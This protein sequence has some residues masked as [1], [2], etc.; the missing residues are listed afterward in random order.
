MSRR[1]CCSTGQFLCL[2]AANPHLIW[3][4]TAVEFFVVHGFTQA[5]P[6]AVTEPQFTHDFTNTGCLTVHIFFETPSIS[7]LGWW[8]LISFYVMNEWRTRFLLWALRYSPPKHFW[9][10]SSLVA[11][12]KERRRFS[13]LFQNE[14]ISSVSFCHH[15]VPENRGS[16]VTEIGNP[17]AVECPLIPKSYTRRPPLIPLLLKTNRQ[18]I[19]Y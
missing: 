8:I 10:Q 5:L 2:A 13:L 12:A 11:E 15:F 9:Q 4:N 18:S 14:I 3:V 19:M 6:A 17:E 1:V 7:G 16:S